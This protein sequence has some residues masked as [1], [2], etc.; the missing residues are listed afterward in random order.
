[1]ANNSARWGN[2]ANYNATPG[3][4]T[5]GDPSGLEVSSTGALLVSPAAGA[6]FGNSTADGATF[7][8]NTTTGGLSMG[9]YVSSPQ[10][11]TSGNAGAIAVD[12]SR[13]TMVAEQFAPVYEDNTV[14]VAKVEQRYNYTNI[15]TQTTTTIFSGVGFLHAIVFNKP[16]ASGVV[17]ID[18]A[19]TDTTP[20]VGTITFPATLLTDVGTYTYNCKLTA[21]LTIVTSGATQDITV[22]WRSAT[23]T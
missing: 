19:T 14:G 7:T 6:S 20:V 16:L 18:D 8:Q 21:G 12:V 15:T 5:D 11:L 22:I 23:I 3:T 4:R 13:N 9:V 17:K 1:M 2:P 10:T